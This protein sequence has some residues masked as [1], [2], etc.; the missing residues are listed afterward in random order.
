[1]QQH[2]KK[3]GGNRFEPQWATGHEAP[4]TLWLVEKSLD[5]IVPNMLDWRTFSGQF[6]IV[7]LHAS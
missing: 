1:M 6:F 3:A 7:L 2:W 5:K 4:C